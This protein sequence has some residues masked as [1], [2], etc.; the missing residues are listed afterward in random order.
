MAAVETMLPIMLSEGYHKGRLSLQRIVEVCCYNPAKIY[1]L[2]PRKGNITVGADADLVLVDLNKKVKVKTS[3]LHTQA[4]YCAY[5][6]WDITGWPVATWLRGEL[7]MK[8]NKIVGKPGVGRW[9]PSD[10]GP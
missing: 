1:G 7:V 9:V 8:E 5:E 4:D 3:A 10:V 2:T 6:G